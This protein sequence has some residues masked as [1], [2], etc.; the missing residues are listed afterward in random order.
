MVEAQISAKNDNLN[1]ICESQQE[2]ESI[3]NQTALLLKQTAED[4]HARALAPCVGDKT[5]CVTVLQTRLEFVGL[6]K[7][8][9]VLQPLLMI[10]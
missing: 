5:Y 2:K 9:L 4:V 1:T 8:H 3:G 6:A 10:G 7:G